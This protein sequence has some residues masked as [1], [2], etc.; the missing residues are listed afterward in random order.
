MT[1]IEKKDYGFKLTFAGSISQDE[2]ASWVSDSKNTLASQTSEFGILV[3][4]RELSPLTPG[5]KDVMQTGQKLYKDKGMKRS[6]VIVSQG[7]ISTQFKMIAQQTGIY[8]WERY[9]DASAN[10]NWENIA[11]NW[12]TNGKDPDVE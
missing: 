5:A 11:T 1:N 4:M 2:M 7:F 10:S 12:I 8:E 3:D 9:I 6:A